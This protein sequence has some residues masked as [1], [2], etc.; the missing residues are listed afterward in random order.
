[1]HNELGTDQSSEEL[2]ELGA[3]TLHSYS[4]NLINSMYSGTA[5]KVLAA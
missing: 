3:E 2:T 4:Q 5:P 1:M